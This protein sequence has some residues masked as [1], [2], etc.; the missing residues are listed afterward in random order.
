M[1]GNPRN[2]HLH[3]YF[4]GPFTVD[5]F[6]IYENRKTT[7]YNSKFYDYVWPVLFGKDFE[8]TEF[9]LEAIE[10]DQGQRILESK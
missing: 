3:G 2:V 5:R 7:C 10:F 8:K 4:M 9:V 1:E 6:A